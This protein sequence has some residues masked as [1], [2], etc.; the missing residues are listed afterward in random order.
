MFADIFAG[1]A[2]HMHHV[3]PP[4]SYNEALRSSLLDRR[5]QK[6]SAACLRGQSL[7]LNPDEANYKIQLWVMTPSSNTGNNIIRCL[8]Q[9]I[10]QTWN[11]VYRFSR[12]NW[13]RVLMTWCWVRNSGVDCV[14]D[15]DLGCR[16]RQKPDPWHGVCKSKESGKCSDNASRTDQGKG[17][18]ETFLYQHGQISKTWLYGQ[19]K[20][21]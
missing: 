5:S 6:G 12:W 20:R 8:I 2:L 3:I 10:L 21:E 9:N 11:D 16:K 19:N 18:S 4:G 14:E 15:S 13:G 7:D 17:T 1:L